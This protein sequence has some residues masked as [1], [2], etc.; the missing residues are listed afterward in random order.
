MFLYGYTFYIN[1]IKYHIR[2]SDTHIS[3][4]KNNLFLDRFVF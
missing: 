3:I 4:W 1:D 2:K